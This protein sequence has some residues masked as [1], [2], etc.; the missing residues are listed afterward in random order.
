[1]G[2]AEK[3]RMKKRKL[4]EQDAAKCSKLTDLFQSGKSK[5]GTSSDAAAT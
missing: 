3:K 5:E 4:L 2:G 1:M